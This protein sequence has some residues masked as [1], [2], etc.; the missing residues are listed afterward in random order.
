MENPRPQFTHLAQNLKELGLAYIHVV[1]SRISGAETVDARAEQ[2][3]FLVDVWGDAGTVIL[4]GGFTPESAEET[5]KKYEGKQVVIAFGR[6]F[7]ANP[8]LPFRISQG[9]SL[10]KYNR[11]TFYIPE[12]PVGY[13]DYPFSEEYLGRKTA[14]Y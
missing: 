2:A 10:T 1:E 4:P 14:V 5:V 13:I 3:D 9:I 11:S 6:N 7:L 8:D 12:S